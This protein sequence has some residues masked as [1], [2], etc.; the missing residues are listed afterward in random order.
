MGDSVP[1]VR[2]IIRSPTIY[3]L[4]VYQVFYY[5]IFQLS[6]HYLHLKKIKEY[7]KTLSLTFLY[8]SDWSDAELKSPPEDQTVPVLISND[9]RATIQIDLPPAGM[10]ILA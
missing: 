9:G 7:E 2:K 8:K 4:Y 3:T 6:F 1:Q 5:K 10:D